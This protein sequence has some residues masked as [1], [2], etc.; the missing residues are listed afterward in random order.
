M[1]RLSCLCCLSLLCLILAASVVTPKPSAAFAPAASPGRALMFVAYNQVWW[2]EYKVVYEALRAQ[3]YTVDVR[4]SA[5]GVARSYGDDIS[6][7]PNAPGTYAEFQ[8]LFAANFG[9]A[10]NPA[11]NAPADIPLNGRLQDVAD[12]SSYDLLV[13]PGGV[14]MVAYRYDGSYAALGPGDHQTTAAEVQ[15]AAEKLNALIAEA[16]Q[17]GKPVGAECHGAPTL[18]FARVPGTVGQ[19]FDGLGRSILQGRNATGYPLGDGDTAAVYASLGVT[20]L[21]EKVALDGPE[22]PDFAGQGRDVVVTGQDWYPQTAVYFARTLLNMLDTYPTPAQRAR[23]LRVLVFGGDEPQNYPQTPAR[24]T[25]L[26]NL[27]NDNSDEFN[28]TAIGTN[29]PA[30]ITLSNLQNYDVLVYFRHNAVDATLQNAVTAYVDGGGGLVAVHHANYNHNNQNNILNTLLGGQLPYTVTLNSDLGLRY[31]GEV[32]HVLNVNL[33]HFVSTYGTP[34]THTANYTTPLGLP[35]ANVD[36]DVARGY[37]DFTIPADDELYLGNRFNPGVVFGRGVNHINRIFANDHF[38][39]TS[40]NPNNGH[41]DAWGWVRLYDGDDNGLVGRLVY[42]QPGET[43][44]RTLSHPTYRQ[45]IK[46]AVVWTA[47]T[48]PYRLY[49]PWLTR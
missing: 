34:L 8:A 1:S 19:G 17:T 6:A 45:V 48:Q 47:S 7:V 20:Y 9:A 22:A 10:W 49:L 31:F 44:D 28:I 33:G 43:N 3:G 32:N 14:G 30:T 37:Y 4:S 36:A 18:A 38:T 13:I 41:Y 39:A 24:Y 42:L 46:N 12:L 40:A 5:T 16:L 27:L 2:S 35:N 15:A 11:W 26:V 21:N 29:N 25:D 23:T